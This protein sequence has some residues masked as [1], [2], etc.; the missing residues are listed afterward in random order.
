MTI[1]LAYLQTLI[2]PAL[3]VAFVVF[4]KC[5]IRTFA[6]NLAALVPDATKLRVKIANLEIEA[7][8]LKGRLELSD[9]TV[10]S[11]SDEIASEIER[12]TSGDEPLK[13][14]SES[15]VAVRDRINGLYSTLPASS[16]EIG[17]VSKAEMLS[18]EGLMS[19][20]LVAGVERLERVYGRL[21]PEM[22]ATSDA[23]E[24][25]EAG[26]IAARE[27]ALEILRRLP[28]VSA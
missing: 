23:S 15:V 25:Y 20:E 1:A 12:K 5:P 4:L 8:V 10:D 2:W 19:D 9:T 16:P 17:I 14:L 22:D 21:E 28:T 26:A 6:G 13:R 27:L 11:A 24:H 3:V 18:G 7:E